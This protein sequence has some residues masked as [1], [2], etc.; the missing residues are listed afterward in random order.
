MLLKL[1]LKKIH[2]VS[3]VIA[4]ILLIGLTVLAGA[5]LFA[6]VIPL[7]SSGTPIILETSTDAVFSTTEKTQLDPFI[8]TMKFQVSN[9]INDPVQLDL[10][11]SYIYNASNNQILYQWEPQVNNTE[12]SLS[13]KQSFSLEYKTAAEQNI[14]ELLYGQSV[15]VE[16]NATKYGSQTSELIKSNIYTV[17]RANSLP[18][19]DISPVD[20]FTQSGTTVFFEALPNQ[21]ITN[22]S[23]V[24]E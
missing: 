14:E 17:T 7:L 15:Y 24:A 23:N 4:I 21:T 19:F 8:D 16:L 18:I 10:A 5:A 22:S 9:D 6:I 13:G 20:H 3:Q 12:P 11:H 1:K 2:A